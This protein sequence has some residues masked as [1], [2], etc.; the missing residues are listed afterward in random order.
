MAIAE[1]LY[2]RSAVNKAGRMLAGHLNR[3]N[4][5]TPEE[6]EWATARVVD[7][8]TCHSYPLQVLHRSI[9]SASTLWDTDVL[10]VQRLKR[11]ESILLK[12]RRH[13]NMAATQMQDIGGCRA[14]LK[15]TQSACLAVAK[16]RSKKKVHVLH[17]EYDYNA[18]PQPDGY[19][20]IHLVYKFRSRMIPALNDMRIELQFRSMAQHAWATAV[21]IIDTFTGQSLKNKRGEA[22]WR[23]FFALVSAMVAIQEGTA[24]VPGISTDIRTLKRRLYNAYLICGVREVVASIHELEAR[25]ARQSSGDIAYYLLMLNTKDSE[26][27]ILEFAADQRQDAVIAYYEAEQV[28]KVNA[29]MVT[30]GSIQDVK[31]AYPNYFGDLQNFMELLAGLGIP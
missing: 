24:P 7:W 17:E 29:V 5:L 16:L 26:L 3:S 18:I 6:N 30:S 2:S 13:P 1:P 4:R 21:E 15:D 8:R 20:G 10:I 23:N 19:R 9:L 14:I 11:F 25:V 27:E 12:L 28:K 31:E 22:H